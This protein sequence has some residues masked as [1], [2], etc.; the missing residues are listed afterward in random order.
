MSETGTGNDTS[1]EALKRYPAIAPSVAHG[2]INVVGNTQLAAFFAGNTS[3]GTQG[4][5]HVIQGFE[6]G[7]GGAGSAIYLADTNLHVIIQ[8]CTLQGSGNTAGSAGIRLNNC[9]NVIVRW[10]SVTSNAY[11]GVHVEGGSSGITITGNTVSSNAMVGIS[12]DQ[13]RD[14]MVSQNVITGASNITSTGINVKTATNVTVQM[15]NMSSPIANGIWFTGGVYHGRIT[16]NRIANCYYTGISITESS[17]IVVDNNRVTRCNY[18]GLELFNDFCDN[19]ITHNLVMD[20]G[21]AGIRFFNGNDNITGNKIW[22]NAFANNRDGESLTRWMVPAENDWD[23]DGIGN[24]WGDY[25]ERYPDAPQSG[26]IWGTPY[27][28]NE[29]TY[30][31]DF[32]FF[33]LVSI[34]LITGEGT[35]DP[36]GLPGLEVAL[37]IILIAFLA[38]AAM[39]VFKAHKLGVLFPWSTK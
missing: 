15:N 18:H 32:D 2:K 33:P 8:G 19:N 7:A 14:A 9:T 10:N 16:G 39:V 13:A 3:D 21:F 38:A 31:C 5:P 23:V 24:Y 4:N 34:D 20:C 6:I 37:W 35:P 27:E 28:I 11:H 1:D 25:R 17:M 30:T 36:T 12:L 22:F 26:N 29:T